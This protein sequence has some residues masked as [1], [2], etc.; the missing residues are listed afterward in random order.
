MYVNTTIIIHPEIL[1]AKPTPF[2][3]IFNK[4]LIDPP[5]IKLK[6]GIIYFKKSIIDITVSRII[7]V[8]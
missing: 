2:P 1:M 4:M 6:L 3:I 7:K 5:K 8:K